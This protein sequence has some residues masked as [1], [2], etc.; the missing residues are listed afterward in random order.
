MPEEYLDLVD[1]NGNLTGAKQLRSVCHAKGFWHRTVHVYLFRKTGSHMEL[2]TH[3][4]SME[5]E[6]NPGKWSS[7][8]G[9]HVK[10][11]ESAEQ[12]LLNEIREEVGLEIKIENLIRGFDTR[13]EHKKNHE[14]V[15]IWYL[16][17][18]DDI[19][20]LSFNDGE[21][22]QVKWRTFEEIEKDIRENPDRWSTGT[23]IKKLLLVKKDLLKKIS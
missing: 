9:G 2:L 18:E 1:E 3:L 13:Y 23:R 16:Q 20:K 21:V 8:F 6:T 11:G 15:F 10:S 19:A 5:K 12:A 17:Y 7:S 14:F 4:R 22:Q